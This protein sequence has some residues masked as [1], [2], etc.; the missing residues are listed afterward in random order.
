MRASGPAR[1]NTVTTGR[2]RHAVVWLRTDPHAFTDARR[3]V[4]QATATA[5][6]VTMSRTSLSLKRAARATGFALVGFLT[7]AVL[8]IAL[9]NLTTPVQLPIYHALYLSIGPAGAT[10]AALVGQFTIA[11]AIASVLPAIVVAYLLDDGTSGLSDIAPGIGVAVALFVLFALSVGF[12]LVPLPIAAV[13]VALLF[14]AIPVVLAVR[15]DVSSPAL[16]ALGGAVPVIV[17]LFLLL[18]FGMG[19]GWGYVVTATTV[20]ADTVDDTSVADLDDAPR[21]ENDLFTENTCTTTADGREC[22]LQLRGYEH[23]HEAIRFLARHGVRC[24]YGNAPASEQGDAGTLIAE[25]DGDYYRVSC[26][27]HGD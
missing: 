1:K 27:P 21:V 5:V 18:G 15:Y 12:R 4:K 13:G 7:T 23:E 17:V 22:I 20:S 9:V 6:H 19:W 26:H 2:T 8:A 10:Q 3:T 25:H 11:I 24:P 16:P 14:L